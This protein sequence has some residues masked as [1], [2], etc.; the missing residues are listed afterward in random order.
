ME[1]PMSEKAPLD[2]LAHLGTCDD[3]AS[4]PS[5]AVSPFSLQ[6]AIADPWCYGAGG[7]ELRNPI[8]NLLFW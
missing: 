2:S 8:R 1:S 7:P 4:G 5:M 3:D 6:V